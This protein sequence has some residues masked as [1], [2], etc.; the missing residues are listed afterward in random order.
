MGKAVD[1]RLGGPQ[2]IMALV[3]ARAKWEETRDGVE[4]PTI[5]PSYNFVM[6]NCKMRSA[7]ARK[8]RIRDVI[9]SVR[10]MTGIA[11]RCG[12][13]WPACMFLDWGP[14]VDVSRRPAWIK[15]LA[16][17]PDSESVHLLRTNVHKVGSKTA[18]DVEAHFNLAARMLRSQSNP[19]PCLAQNQLTHVLIS[20]CSD[21]SNTRPPELTQVHT[22]NDPPEAS[23]SSTQARPLT[24]Y[25]IAAG[26]GS[27]I[28][29][30]EQQGFKCVGACEIDNYCR[31]V[32]TRVYPHV[33]LH[34][35][36]KTLDLKAAC[37]EG[38]PLTLVVLS[39]PCVD[40]SARGQLKAQDGEVRS[41]TLQQHPCNSASLNLSCWLLVCMTSIRKF[42]H[43]KCQQQ[44]LRRSPTSSSRQ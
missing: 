11:A 19:M 27:G 10:I 36:I 41:A 2:F 37:S 16:G 42:S 29:D 13:S 12:L 24:F 34:D 18:S 5:Q 7:S 38:Q 25:Y 31:E 39:T 43:V 4:P 1:V 21:F 44:C 14:A 9:A 15:A 20:C 28:A 6:S 32:L 35:D 22:H 3:I 17:M 33:P 8:Q 26:I 40:V 30:M 23:N